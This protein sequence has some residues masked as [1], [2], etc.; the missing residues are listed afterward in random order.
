MP[1]FAAS[2]TMMFNEWD[3]LD[4]FEQ[5]AGAGFDGVEIQAPY[6]ESPRAIA[7]RV[8][9]HG[10]DAVLMNVP[11]AAGA[12]PDREQEYRDGLTQAFEYAAAAGCDQIHCLAGFT[13][14]P[15]AEETFVSNLRWASERARPL[16][17]RLLLEPLNTQDNPGYF[18]TGSAQARGVIERV[19][20]DNVF[21]QYDFYHMQ[22]MEGCLA[23]TVRANIDIIGHFQIGG[24]PG[25]HE[26]NGTQEINFP[27][28]FDVI[29]D[30]G[31]E[32]W[33]G[34]EYRPAGDTLEGLAW[35]RPYG[36]GAA[37]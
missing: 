12:V 19:G 14:D 34:C 28:L 10:L 13:D 4:R 24:V 1:R 3:L 22:I 20:A 32:G 26:P 17:I 36:I 8:R 27:Y 6:G 16:G 11:A 30:L 21:L 25:R 15:R 5:A 9:R 33:V 7:E 31:F 37:R 29:D 18:L 35:A 23:E 2:V